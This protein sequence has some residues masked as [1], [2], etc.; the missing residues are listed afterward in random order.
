MSSDTY[1]QYTQ[2][3]NQLRKEANKIDMHA[4]GKAAYFK[5]ILKLAAKYKIKYTRNPMKL[6]T[7]EEAFNLPREEAAIKKCER[8]DP[9]TLPYYAPKGSKVANKKIDCDMGCFCVD[10]GVDRKSLDRLNLNP[11]IEIAQVCDGDKRHKTKRDGKPFFAFDFVSK[12]PM[13]KKALKQLCDIATVDI[14]DPNSP[15]TEYR[16]CEN[17]PM[18]ASETKDFRR[19]KRASNIEGAKYNKST[20]KRLNNPVPDVMVF[21]RKSNTKEFWKLLADTL[22]KL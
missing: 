5:L 6:Y 3:F 7:P 20:A 19:R 14:D 4:V 11:N 12:R 22:D 13:N 2:R 1:E 18:S 9:W 8:Y 10:K 15:N 17:K 16:F 21:G